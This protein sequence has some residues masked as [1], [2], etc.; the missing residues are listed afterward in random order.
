MPEVLE[1]R[2]EPQ[3]NGRRAEEDEDTQDHGRCEQGG[4]AE[5]T[6]DD[7][8]TAESERAVEKLLER[9]VTVAALAQ[10]LAPL[11]RHGLGPFVLAALGRGLLAVAKSS[12]AD[13]G[14]KHQH[15]QPADQGSQP[16]LA[17]S[18]HVLSRTLSE[19]YRGPV[20][21]TPVCESGVRVLVDPSFG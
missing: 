20:D 17:A 18:Q 16:S 6:V 15:K 8:V 2:L 5:R 14:D 10:E 19:R 7:E 4:G 1:A 9:Y 11:G 12:E 3:P 21:G 13:H